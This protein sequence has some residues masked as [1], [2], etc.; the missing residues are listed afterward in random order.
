M[1]LVVLVLAVL[2]SGV[3]VAEDLFAT[4]GDEGITWAEYEA[5]V[6]TGLRQRFFHGKVPEAELQAFREEMAQ[7]L[8]DRVLL[9][10]EARRRGLQPQA[11]HVEAA[12]EETRQRYRQNPA[13]K[14]QE[15]TVVARLRQAVVKRDLITQLRQQVV[16]Q[17]IRVDSAQA[18]EAAVRRYY[19]EHPEQFT[20]P[21]RLRLS[22]IMLGVEPWAPQAKWRAAEQEAERLVQ[23]LQSGH[24]EFTELA[25]LHSSDAS[26]S[27]GGDL[28]Y[29][30]LGM[31]SPEAQKHVEG[32]KPGEVA[33]PLRLLQGIAI[34]RLDGRLPAQLNGF[35]QVR[36]RARGLLQRQQQQQAWLQLIKGLRQRTPVQRNDVKMNND[37]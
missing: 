33:A 23:K 1:K 18:E 26:S 15:E 25:R 8:I 11:A 28:G 22:L 37:G 19:N 32:L 34:F 16:E 35:D 31:L 5:H 6:D 14:D 2:L 27:Q 24:A 29:I 21:E 12:I 9:V 17:A 7:E 10:R 30:H 20:T 36:E 3:A 13:W 4:V